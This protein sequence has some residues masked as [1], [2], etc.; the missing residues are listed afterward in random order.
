MNQTHKTYFKTPTFRSKKLNPAQFKKLTLSIF[1]RDG[2]TCQYCGKRY[3]K[4]DHA[5]HP[6]HIKFRSQGGSDTEGN[7]ISLCWVCHRKLHDGLIPRNL[8]KC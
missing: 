7:L 4:E 3:P 1:A 5:L 2:Y 8:K 6:H